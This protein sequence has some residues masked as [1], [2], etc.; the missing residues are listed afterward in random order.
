MAEVGGEKR[1]AES[2]EALR[3]LYQL[4]QSQYSAVVNEMNRNLEYIRE[5]NDAQ[6]TLEGLGSVKKKGALLSLG[7]G[8][9]M[10]AAVG[11]ADRVLVG[12]GAGYMVER[13]PVEA[14][15]LVSGRVEKATLS[16]NNL[17]RSRKELEKAIA[18]VTNRMEALSR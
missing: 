5:L 7:A 6:R 1:P 3:Y 13:S 12:V 11:D 4:Y 9:Y 14:R 2:I 18:E 15:N 17:V 8:V 16:F 10:D